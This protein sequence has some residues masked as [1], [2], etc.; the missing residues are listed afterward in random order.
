MTKVDV[1]IP[2]YRG[3]QE[4][5]DCIESAVA[6]LPLW[7]NIIV[8]NDCSPEHE[9]TEWLRAASK[10]FSF[11]LLENETN[12]GFV[13]TV[14][15]GMSQ[16]L[17][18]DVLLLNSDVEVRN[19][20]LERIREVAYLSEDIGSV[21]PFSNNATICSYPKFCKDN[22]LPS[23]LSLAEIDLAFSKANKPEDFIEIP[24]GVGFCMYIKRTCLDE[25]GLFDVET[26]GKGYG[27]ENDW[28]QR[29]INCGWKNVHATNVFAYHK[30][31]VSFADEQNPRQKVALELL[32][33]KHPNYTADVMYFVSQDPAKL[34]RHRAA[35]ELARAHRNCVLHVEHAL[36]GGVRRHVDDLVLELKPEIN[37]VRL[38]QSGGVVHLYLNESICIKFSVEKERDTLLSV[39][40]YI[41]FSKIHY[42]HIH[43]LDSS[44][45][46]LGSQLSLDYIITIHDYYLI[47]GNV[48]LTD[49]SGVF[50][51]DESV[52]SVIKKSEKN[53]LA[54]YKFS[55]DSGRHEL[56]MFVTEAEMLLFPSSDTMKRFNRFYD[57]AD[58]SVVAPH[59]ER[60]PSEI[61]RDFEFW[62]E[63][64]INVLVLGAISL[65]KGAIILNKFSEKYGSD[66]NI[67]L[68]GYSCIP[69][70]RNIIAHGQY[71]EQDL[72]NK[73]IEISPDVVWYTSQCAETYCYTLSAAI[74]L[75][76]PIVAP[77]IGAF[78]ERL[79]VINNATILDDFK[80]IDKVY[81]AICSKGKLSKGNMKNTRDLTNLASVNFYNGDYQELVK[82][83]SDINP[84]ILRYDEVS[85]LI[86]YREREDKKNFQESLYDF[87]LE[88]YRT[89]FGQ[90]F[91]SLIPPQ[92]LRQI[93]R[94]LFG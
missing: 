20:W 71:I 79:S 58:K 4:T 90:L 93:K 62:D 19:D 38:W 10:R 25:V 63:E 41:G 82:N 61:K 88:I 17:E 74:V 51:G 64:R 6:T 55:S 86:F 68:L 3:L 65:E 29:A 43:G 49:S 91:A 66:V 30:G 60:I 87:V 33:K 36:G 1:I 54:G 53:R 44:L 15:I 46:S 13:E 52:E 27:E 78:P 32:L 26:F 80:D 76:L 28:C 34:A 24:T 48:A 12:K 77:N 45:L 57:V 5:S 22:A 11:E 85:Q 16:N 9:V 37:S 72:L 18:R 69:L 23:G 2:V 35:I 81:N 73:I 83:N 8:I 75:N 7:A 84:Y 40:N 21:T 92:K 67:H 47:N 59:I 56:E 89:R 14:N 94:A 70:D 39:L 31:G 50:F 42:H